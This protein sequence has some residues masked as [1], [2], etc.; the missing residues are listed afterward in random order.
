MLTLLLIFLLSICAAF[1]QRVSGFGFG[2]F[3]M[4]FFPYFLPSYGE[5]T[6]LSGLL[7]GSTA[8]IIAVKNWKHIAWKVMMPVLIINLIVSFF[9]IEFMAS[10]SNVAVKRCFGVMFVLIAIYF[11]FLKKKATLP[12]TWWTK[13]IIGVLSGIMGGLFAMPGPPLVLYCI[14]RIKKKMPYVVTKQAF[15]VVLNIFYTMFRARVG[16]MNDDTFL[17]WGVGLAGAFIGMRI[18][19]RIFEHISEEMLKKVVYTLMMISGISAVI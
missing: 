9:A 15:S 5:S 18:G 11:L 2:I 4:M 17:W 6:A 10:L 14:T 3:V 8:F 7:A 1:I 16:F 19:G 13:G 12:D